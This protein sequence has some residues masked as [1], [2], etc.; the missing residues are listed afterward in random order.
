MARWAV[1]PVMMRS[2][3]DEEQRDILGLPAQEVRVIQ[4]QATIDLD[5]V[6]SYAKLIDEN[7]DDDDTQTDVWMVSGGYMIIQM[8]FVTFDK[9]IR[10]TK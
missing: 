9:L 1:V 3:Q 7:G 4:K 6:E 2:I 10:K 8:P 5:R